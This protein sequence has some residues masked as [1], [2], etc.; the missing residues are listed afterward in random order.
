MMGL[1]KKYYN[2]IKGFHDMG[3]TKLSYVEG[4]K[5]DATK[6]LLR[7]NGR[8]CIFCIRGFREEGIQ[9]NVGCLS[10]ELFSVHDIVFDATKAT[11]TTVPEVNYHGNYMICGG[12]EKFD[13]HLG[14]CGECG[15]PEGNGGYHT[16][17]LEPGNFVVPEGNWYCPDCLQ[18]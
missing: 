12:G 16:Y 3:T 15:D 7:M 4:V 8:F 14:C 13:E 2:D 10:K 18:P 17:C 11:P 5:T 6:L 9:Y 1:V